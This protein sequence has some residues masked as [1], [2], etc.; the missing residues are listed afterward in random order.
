MN[1]ALVVRAGEDNN[2]LT[3]SCDY[4]AELLESSTVERLVGHLGNLLGAMVAEPGTTLDRLILLGEAELKRALV[5]WNAT[6]TEFPKR[7]CVHQLIEA[8]ARRAPEVVA[9]ICRNRQLTYAELNARA[10]QVASHLSKLGVG[11]DTV[12]GLCVDRSLQMLVGLLGILKSG[13][14]YLPLDPAY[15]SERLA[16]MIEDARLKALL[17]QQH[18]ERILPPGGATRVRL[19][20]DWDLTRRAR[21]ASPRA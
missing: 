11:P 9:V 6:E 1:C 16:F 18:L 17:T 7:A 10:N 15:P 20:A 5:D 13:G 2:G 3:L 12:V 8:Q 21:P 14:A 19:D 4:D